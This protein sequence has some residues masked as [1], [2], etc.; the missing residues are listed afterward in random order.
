VQGAPKKK[1]PSQNKV[2]I[3]ITVI[4]RLKPVTKEPQQQTPTLSQCL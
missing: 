3:I 4:T 2:K 1:H